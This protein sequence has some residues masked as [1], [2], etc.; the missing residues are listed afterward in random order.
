MLDHLWVFFVVFWYFD[1]KVLQVKLQAH[2]ILRHLYIQ[3]LEHLLPDVKLL[4]GG[5]VALDATSTTVF[6]SLARV[7]GFDAGTSRLAELAP[8]L[9]V[10]AELAANLA[11]QIQVIICLVAA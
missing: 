1:R 6:V 3:Y 4:V 2:H 11:H 9:A 5:Q 10:L 7:G 8:C